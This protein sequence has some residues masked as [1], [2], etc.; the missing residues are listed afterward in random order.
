[1]HLLTVVISKQHK[2]V[3]EWINGEFLERE[4]SDIKVY[5]R[6]SKEIGV[7][8]KGESTNSWK[9]IVDKIVFL[10]NIL[11]TQKLIIKFSKQYLKP[12]IKAD[13]GGKI[14]MEQS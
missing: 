9:L 4:N 13:Y 6:N 8:S 3:N 12:Q 7:V 14:F 5:S 10:T 2:R 11:K 1:M